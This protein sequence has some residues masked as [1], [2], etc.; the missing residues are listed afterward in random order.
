MQRPKTSFLFD[1]DGT[2]VDSVYQ[3]VLSWREALEAEGI[4]L[5]IWRIHRKIGWRWRWQS[6]L[7]SGSR[8]GAAR[9]KLNPKHCKSKNTTAPLWRPLK[10]CGSWDQGTSFR[11]WH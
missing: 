3:H 5:S 9:P 1:L 7:S 8:D 4:A 2:L 6:S 10:G 11:R